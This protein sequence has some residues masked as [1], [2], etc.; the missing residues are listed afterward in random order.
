MHLQGDEKGKNEK[1]FDERKIKCGLKKEVKKKWGKMV[2]V[3]WRLNRVLK[4]FHVYRNMEK[5]TAAG[6]QITVIKWC[7]YFM[8]KY[9][10]ILP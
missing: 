6:R 8:L 4:V 2:E 3:R 1:R 7:L 10:D 9:A 5:R